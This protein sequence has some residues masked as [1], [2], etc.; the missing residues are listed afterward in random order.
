LTHQAKTAAFTR[1]AAV[2]VEMEGAAVARVAAEAG[3][4]FASVRVILDDAATSLPALGP[5][6]KTM[7]DFVHKMARATL[8]VQ[9]TTR[10]V[11][12]ARNAL[13]VDH[14]LGRLFNSWRRKNV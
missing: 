6:S 3:I 9:E 7:F 5:P 2:A 13:T 8:S 10:F 11:R 14:T 12:L 1:H 4:P